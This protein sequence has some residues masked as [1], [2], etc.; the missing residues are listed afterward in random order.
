MTDQLSDQTRC[1]YYFPSGRRCRQAVSSEH[2][3]FC[4]T[5]ARKTSAPDSPP[6]APL[7]EALSAEIAQLAG[8]FSSPAQVNLVM[9]K[10]FDGL[11]HGRISAKEAGVLCYIAQTILNSQRTVGYLQ[12]SSAQ[13]AAAKPKRIVY[14]NDLPQP[15]RD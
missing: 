9:G 7:D 6:D 11:L 1:L 10:I 3:N 13:A 4:A 5:H 15:L 2:P 14:I 12:R 8:D